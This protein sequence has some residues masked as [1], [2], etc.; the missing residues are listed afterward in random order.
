M[1]YLF[2]IIKLLILKV[3][4]YYKTNSEIV[5]QPSRH[6]AAAARQLQLLKAGS[7]F[8]DWL[9]FMLATDKLEMI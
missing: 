2:V 4:H 8:Y 7:I 9:S 6:Q 1:Y 5:L 3:N